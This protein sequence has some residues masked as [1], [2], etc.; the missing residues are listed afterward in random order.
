MHA[1]E[2][3]V[4]RVLRAAL[5]L[6]PTQPATG[7]YVLPSVDDALRL[8]LAGEDPTAVA[9]VFPAL[10]L[11][12]EI[13]SPPAAPELA[14][15]SK[16]LTAPVPMP[17]G[18]MPTRTV[19]HITTAADEPVYGPLRRRHRMP[20]EETLRRDHAAGGFVPDLAPVYGVS[21]VGLY[22]AWRRLGLKADARTRKQ[23][24][25]AYSRAD[26]CRAG[27]AAASASTSGP[28]PAGG[29]GTQMVVYAEPPP[30]RLALDDL[31]LA[32]ELAR[33]TGISRDE[34][35]AYLRAD[36]EAASGRS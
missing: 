10:D 9:A 32:V 26:K 25:S 21:V 27:V 16:T 4:G 29:V 22:A 5:R 14:P 33:T 19:H 34:A 3:A 24:R 1:L 6:V 12:P 17:K 18:V 31:A 36:I 15:V 30:G 23:R 13:E 11:T 2:L 8:A 28:I 7:R 20:D 35:I